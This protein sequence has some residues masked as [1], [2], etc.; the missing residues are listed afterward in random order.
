MTLLWLGPLVTLGFVAG[1]A[2]S[3]VLLRM[4]YLSRPV[5][6]LAAL[7]L[8][9]GCAILPVL[10]LAAF[11]LLGMVAAKAFGATGY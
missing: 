6:R 10:I 8:P 7:G 3:A 9:F 11:S 4:G 2:T 5:A 1:F